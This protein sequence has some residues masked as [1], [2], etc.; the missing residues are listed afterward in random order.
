M[1]S[2]PAPVSSTSISIPSTSPPTTSTSPPTTST[3]PPKRRKVKYAKA[4]GYLLDPYLVYQQA[5]KDGTAIEGQYGQTFATYRN[6]LARHC[7]IKYDDMV[8][9][10]NPRPKMPPIYCV[11]A[12][13][14]LSKR[15]RIPREDIIEKAKEFLGTTEEPKWYYII[16][17]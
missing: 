15:S 16:R 8:T 2:T 4:F 10:R 5:I 17:A 9:I 11:V 1:S 13:T 6:R 12:A 14:N 3:S 7:G